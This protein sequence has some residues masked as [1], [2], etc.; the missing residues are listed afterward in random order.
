MNTTSESGSG[1][2][3]ESPGDSEKLLRLAEALAHERTVLRTMID[4]ISAF[5]YVKDAQ[6]RFTACNALVAERLGTSPDEMIGKTDCDFFPQPMAEIFFAEEQALIAS[7]VPLIDLEE[8]AFDK[9]CGEN[10]V[11]V[12]VTD[13]G[14]GI[15]EEVRGRIFGPFST[16]KAV[17]RGSGQGLTM[18]RNVVVKGHDGEIDFST[19]VGKG[20]T[21]TFRLPVRP[22]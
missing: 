14:C 21:S 22:E 5:I 8:G 16:T 2:P 18:A 1:K 13:N 4:L 12:S 11:V 3:A 10:R 9:V 17:G 7:G 19:E 6:S 20:T 15:R